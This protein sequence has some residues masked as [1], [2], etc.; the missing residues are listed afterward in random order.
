MIAAANPHAAQIGHD[1]LKIGGTAADAAV[2]VQFML[3]LVEPQSSGIGGGAFM[4]YW[5]AENGKLH[6][7]DGRE[8]A[9]RLATP[10]YFLNPTEHRKDGGNRSS[11]AARWEC[12]AR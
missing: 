4:L 2:A 10:E 3:N 11:A 5:D 6:T 1:I 8:K 12:R 9:P 7:F